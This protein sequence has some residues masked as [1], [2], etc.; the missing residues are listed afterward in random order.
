MC[1][2]RKIHILTIEMSV[3]MIR[4]MSSNNTTLLII[5]LK[6]FDNEGKL[7]QQYQSNA[8]RRFVDKTDI[9]TERNIALN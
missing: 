9:D 1:E 7:N 8:T 5:L 2:N 4:I 3:K 6:I